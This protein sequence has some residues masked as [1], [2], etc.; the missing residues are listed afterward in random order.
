LAIP[1]PP[2]LE[3]NLEKIRSPGQAHTIDS[4]RGVTLS[5][6]FKIFIKIKHN[7]SKPLADMLSKLAILQ[8]FLY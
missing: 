7:D 6:S 2:P 1:P 8:S 5:F 4:G 3:P